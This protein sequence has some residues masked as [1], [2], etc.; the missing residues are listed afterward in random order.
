[1]EQLQYHSLNRG[2][3]TKKVT[4]KEKQEVAADMIK[5]NTILKTLLECQ[6]YRYNTGLI[7]KEQ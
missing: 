2:L 1:M 6:I 5:V 3:G 4:K 7:M